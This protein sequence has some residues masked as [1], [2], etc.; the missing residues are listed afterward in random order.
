M[1]ITTTAVKLS[2]IV[3]MS[4]IPPLRDVK[5]TVGFK[6]TTLLKLLGVEI[7]PSVSVPRVPAA[8]PMAVATAEPDE[9][10]SGSAFG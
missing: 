7:L 2:H 5:P 8:K 10:P 3:E 9:D 4:D 1:G 6:P